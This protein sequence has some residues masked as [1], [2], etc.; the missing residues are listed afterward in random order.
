MGRVTSDDVVVAAARGEHWALESLFVRYWPDLL[1]FFRGRGGGHV[2]EELAMNVWAALLDG[3]L[4][5]SRSRSEHDFRRLLF[6]VARRRL[7]DHLRLRMLALRGVLASNGE[8]VAARP[9]DDPEAHVIEGLSSEDVV[10]WVHDVLP[11]AQAE[12]VVLRVLSG[13]RIDEVAAMVGRSPKAVSMLYRRGIR[14]LGEVLA[15]SDVAE[16]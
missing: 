1:G 13:L 10:R 6:T 3:A 15:P 9:G 2:A 5:R 14:R 4:R 12:V 16:G 11:L 8:L 7:V